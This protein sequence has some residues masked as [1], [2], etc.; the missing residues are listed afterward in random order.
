V[1]SV[2]LSKTGRPKD[3]L[4]RW[5]PQQTQLLHDVLTT[6]ELLRFPNVPVNRGKFVDQSIR[7]DATLL[8]GDD[9]SPVHVE[10][11]RDTEG[12]RALKR[13]IRMYVGLHEPVIWIAP[14]EARMD[15][16]RRHCKAIAS[17]SFFKVLGSGFL[18]SY[19]GSEY[20]AE[21][22]CPASSAQNPNGSDFA[23]KPTGFS[24]AY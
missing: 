24:E 4:C 6:A 10:L 20:L 14:S 1:G 2:Q 23:S 18:Y 19:D 17:D 16:I 5:Q 9:F 13:R 22:F 21:F 12:Y 7:P 3:V 8:M 15:G 11:D